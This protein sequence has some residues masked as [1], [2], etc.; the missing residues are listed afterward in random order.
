MVRA[1]NPERPIETL[2]PAVCHATARLNDKRERLPVGP[3]LLRLAHG[4]SCGG[5][6]LCACSAFLRRHGFKGTLATN[7]ATLRTLLS[8]ELKNFRR[9]LLRRHALILT[10][11]WCMYAVDFHCYLKGV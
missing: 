2:L 6:R 5:S 4:N 9:K 10:R 7:L 11:F 8:E 1:S 3:L